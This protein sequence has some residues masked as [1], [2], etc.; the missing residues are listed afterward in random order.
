MRLYRHP[1]SKVWFYQ[2]RNRRRSLRTKDEQAARLAF[3]IIQRREVDPAYRPADSSATVVTELEAFTEY[4]RER[5]RSPG[6]LGMYET[7][8]RHVVAFFG[9]ATPI[10]HVDADRVHAFFQKR[11]RDGADPSTRWKERCT[12]RGTL[13]LSRKRGRYPFA[14]DDV[15]PDDMQPTYTPGT[16]HLMLPEVIA[17]LAELAP[18]RRAVVCFVVATGADKASVWRATPVDFTET[19][20]RVHGSKTASRDR[21]VPRLAVFAELAAEAEA[22]VPFEPWASMRRDLMRAATRAGVGPLAR[23]ASEDDERP[24]RHITVRDL[25]RSTGRILRAAGVH[26][27]LIGPMLGHAAGSRVTAQTYAQIEPAELGAQIDAVTGDGRKRNVTR[28][29]ARKGAKGRRRRAA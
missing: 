2:Y 11:T 18:A 7:H 4:K 27:S 23:G 9:A 8:A 24:E 1:K 28:G 20:I 6:T 3:A 10:A 17:L 22:G 21:V 12:L 16:R 26:P 29:A 25:R 13:K 15:L 5:G 19:S 14:V